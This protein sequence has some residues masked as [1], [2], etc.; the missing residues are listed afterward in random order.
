MSLKLIGIAA[1]FSLNAMAAD[2]V[3]TTTRTACSAD[4]QDESYKKCGGLQTCAKTV[5]ADS[6]AAC[7]AAAITACKNDR[8]KITKYKTVTAVFA[9]Q[10][11]ARGMDFCDKDADG[12]IVRENF[13]YRNAPSC[14]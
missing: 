13:P 12:Y 3:I 8:F 4:T 5:A 11:F 10:D 9:G 14:N 2:C 7:S 6:E 1:L